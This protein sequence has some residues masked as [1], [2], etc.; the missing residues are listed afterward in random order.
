MTTSSAPDTDNEAVPRLLKR[1]AAGIP[2]TALGVRSA[3]TA[4]IAR[5][6]KATGHDLVWVDLEHSSMPIDAAVQ[7]CC[8]AHDLGMV[9]LVRVPERD[10]GVIGRLLDGGA[11]GIIAPRV[12]TAA[13]AADVV[14]ACRFPPIG[15]RSAIAQLPTL[16]YQRMPAAT[17]NPICNRNTLVKLLIES[18]AGIANLHEIAAVPGV[19]L[20]GVG[21]N[22]LSAELGVP[23]EYRHP[24]MRAAF[25]AA[26]EACRRAGRPL[27]IGGI[28]DPVHVAELIR[29]GVVP[30]MMTGIDTEMMLAAAQERHDKILSSLSVRS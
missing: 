30:F 14:A 28:G 4:E 8:C 24:A 26:I 23:G 1:L 9:S 21:A 16:H 22:D 25:D 19:D 15:H 6:A 20:I 5:I 12:E 2:I 17:L 11:M 27:A 7:I 18:A 13:Q 3:R 10:Y 29:Q